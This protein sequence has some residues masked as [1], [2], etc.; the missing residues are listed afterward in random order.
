MSATATPEASASSGTSRVG[1]VRVDSVTVA[2][3]RPG[4][5]F[6]TW[7]AT[8]LTG[9]R[10]PL[11]VVTLS[12]GHPHGGRRGERH[13]QRPRLT[14]VLVL[15]LDTSCP[16]V[17]AA[18]IELTPAGARTVCEAVV[19]DG[20]RHGELLAMGARD[21]L[22]GVGPAGVEAVVAGTGPGPFTGL[23]VALVSAA[24]FADAWGVPAYGVCSLDGVGVGARIVV[25]DARRRE[26]YWARYDEHGVRIDGPHVETPA[27]L[28]ARL[29]PRDVL[30]GDGAHLHRAL[31]ELAGLQVL[32]APRYPSVQKLVERAADRIRTGEPGDPLTPRYLRR[33]DALEPGAVKRVTA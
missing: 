22:A 2:A 19:I 15:G 3:E 6:L 29:S 12:T 17:S 33:P 13:V 11:A 25:M 31:L 20:R 7:W 26:V 23:R 4:R 18:L 8:V 30:V 10:V 5:I 16:A 14:D 1:A 27:V 9:T 28:A 32:D 24:A 21:V